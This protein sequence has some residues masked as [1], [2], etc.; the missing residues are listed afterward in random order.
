M[1]RVGLAGL[2][3]ANR[4]KSLLGDGGLWYNTFTNSHVKEN[5]S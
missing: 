3:S 4:K 2:R 5:K 1:E